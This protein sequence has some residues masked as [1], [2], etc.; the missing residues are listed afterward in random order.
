M[1]AELLVVTACLQ[2]KGG[3]TESSSAYYKSNKDLQTVVEHA[4]D[5]GKRIVNGNEW[6]VYAA[7]PFYA[8]LSGQQANFKL[9]RQWLLGVN[10]KKEN[11]VLQWSY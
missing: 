10:V 4:E 5:Y 11:I 1:L 9:S 3:C 2:D 6:I 7:T 8:A